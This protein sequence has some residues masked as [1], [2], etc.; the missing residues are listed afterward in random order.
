M[1]VRNLLEQPRIWYGGDYNPEQ[2]PEEVWHE[3]VRLMQQAGV[4]LVSIGIFAW[5]YLEPQPGQ[6]DFAWLDRLMDLLYDHGVHVSL[7][8]ATASPPPWL[9]HRHPNSLP[10]TADG[11]TLWPGGRQAYCLHSQAYMKAAS[12]LVTRL[13]ECYKDH[14]ALAIWHINNEYGCHVSECFC[15]VSAA[16]FRKWLF[17]RYGTLDELNRAWGT[18]FW[19]QRYGQWEEINPPRRAPTF[20][21]P[22][23]QLDWRRFSSDSLIALSDMETEILRGITPDVPVTTNFMGFFKPADY[24][25]WAHRE[26]VVSLDTYPDPSDAFAA[27]QNAAQCDLTRSLGDGKP[28]MLMEQTSS[29][30]NWRPRNVLK[31]PGQMRLWSMQALARGANTV[32]F[33]QWRAARAGAEKFHGALV[34]HV[35][36][37]DSRVWREVSALGNELQELGPLA[38]SRVV[39][40][41]GILVDWQSWWALELDSKPSTAVTFYDRLASFY[42]PLFAANITADFAFTD[43]D[44]ANYK[45]IFVP[46]LYLVDDATA[47]RLEEY[48]AGGGT[49]I[50]GFFSG[51]VDENEHIRL[52]GYPAPFRKLLGIRVEEF[53]PMADGEQNEVRF[54]DGSSSAC[55]LWADVIDLEGATALATFTGNFYAGRPAITEHTFGRGRAIYIGTRLAP[56]TTGALLG[57]LS[58]AAGVTPPVSAP[59][60]VE[61]V[62]RRT[63]DGRTLWFVL[64]HRPELVT[65]TLPAAGIDVLT[66]AEV[67]GA[68]ALEPYGVLIVQ[69]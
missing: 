55:G 53:A 40:D 5:S 8:T 32:M 63:D 30:V 54:A 23:Q 2:W 67:A 13:A 6:Y 49:L 44:F 58:A 22:T 47:A 66:G 31:Q 39:A 16:A 10:V 20:A 59:P 35:G 29:A 48:V 19:S 41:A 12:A 1:S 60:G 25:K 43:S 42:G 57:R 62:R 36:T 4:N 3:D 37:Q 18:A 52:G 7:G 34:P 11:V 14:P 28:W 50:M 24:R 65:V 33:F 56:E 64:N 9:A 51:I 21:N 61:V 38:Q 17:E 68:V 46:N 45:V 27:A 15:D 69:V 26:D